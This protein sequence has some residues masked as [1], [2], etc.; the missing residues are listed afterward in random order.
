MSPLKP[1]NPNRVDHEKYKIEEAKDKD[2]KIVFKN[3]LKACT[4]MNA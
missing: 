2:F 1:N 4:P 3:M